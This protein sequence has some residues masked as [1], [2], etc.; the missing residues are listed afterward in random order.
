MR[1]VQS[2]LCTLTR[3]GFAS[4]NGQA[5]RLDSAY[6]PVSCLKRLVVLVLVDRVFPL[7]LR[8]RKARTG[9]DYASGALIPQLQSISHQGRDLRPLAPL[10]TPSQRGGGYP[11]RQYSRRDS[12]AS[13]RGGVIGRIALVYLYSSSGQ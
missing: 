8:F 7:C 5:R 9:C 3:R 10:A 6:L 4:L 1:Y 13:V 2:L 12:G 11:P